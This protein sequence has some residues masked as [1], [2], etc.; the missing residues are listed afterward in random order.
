MGKYIDIVGKVFGSYTVLEK[1]KNTSN[2]STKFKCKCECGNIKEV[3]GVH[4][5]YGKS[6]QCRTCFENKHD[7]I[8]K[9]FGKLLVLQENGLTNTKKPIKQWLCKCDCGNEVNITTQHLIDGYSTSCGCNT[10]YKDRTTSAFNSL[11]SNYKVGATSRNLDFDLTRDEFKELTLKPC[12]YCGTLPINKNIRGTSIYI[13]NGIDRLDNNIGYNIKNVVTCCSKC[14]IAKHKM[15]YTDFLI[16]ISNIYKNLKL[17][18]SN[19]IS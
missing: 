3:Y 14:N 6:K 12:H 9:K 10:K 4:L 11:F 1:I 7:L 16:L 13:Y 8:N 2:T 19:A 18:G 5:R 15:T 17:G